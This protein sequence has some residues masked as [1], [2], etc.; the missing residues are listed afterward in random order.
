VN[1]TPN[2]QLLTGVALT[3][4]HSLDLPGPTSGLRIT[5]HAVHPDSR[6]VTLCGSSLSQLPDG[7]FSWAHDDVTH[8]CSTCVQL[9]A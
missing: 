8:P 7:E 1:H 2:R 6:F 9:G 5:G 3:F 4:S